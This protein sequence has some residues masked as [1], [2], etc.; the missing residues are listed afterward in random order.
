MLEFL[1]ECQAKEVFPPPPFFIIS[2]RNLVTNF[3]NVGKLL[4]LMIILLG[5]H[6]QQ[7][8][9][10][11]SHWTSNHQPLVIYASVSLYGISPIPIRLRAVCPHI[12][13]ESANWEADGMLK[14]NE[15]GKITQRSR[16]VGTR[17]LDRVICWMET[18]AR[19][20]MELENVDFVL[21]GL[22]FNN[23]LIVSF[24]TFLFHFFS[25]FC[26]NIL[27]I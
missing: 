19:G 23:V 26:I 2:N 10:S 8:P 25:F 9:G 3:E 7:H 14:K 16:T 1:F 11:V 21:N 22:Y 6:V 12:T 4:V 18:L 24:I 20:C 27:F 13:I 5:R 17:S 15:F